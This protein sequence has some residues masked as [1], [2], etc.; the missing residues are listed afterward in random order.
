MVASEGEIRRRRLDQRRLSQVGI[1]VYR[2]ALTAH[3]K[4]AAWCERSRA[5][6][7][8][9]SPGCRRLADLLTGNHLE[10]GKMR[11]PGAGFR[12]GDPITVDRSR[13]ACRSHP[14]ANSAC[15]TTPTS[16]VARTEVPWGSGAERDRGRC[17]THLFTRERILVDRRNGSAA[18]R[19]PARRQAWCSFARLAD[20]FAGGGKNWRTSGNCTRRWIR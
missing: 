10:A 16:A 18:C 5:R 14:D 11:V 8:R 12:C 4:S 1:R 20:S 17:E 3:F 15:S 13:P 19:L 6:L 9:S 2:I 7:R